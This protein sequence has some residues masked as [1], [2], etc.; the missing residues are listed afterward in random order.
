MKP[1]IKQQ[2]AAIIV[3]LFVTALVAA[4]AI[5]MMQRLAIDTRRTELILNANQTFF[6]AQGAIAW[7]LDQLNNDWKLQ[8]PKQLIDKTPIK[9]TTKQNDTII[10]SVIEDAQA[11]FNLNNLTDKN[12]QPDFKRLLHTIAPKVDEATAQSILLGIID[13][14]TPGLR[15]TTF[16]KY[17]AELNPPYQ[18][19]H[20]P[21]VS[22]SELRLIKDVSAEIYNQLAPFI[23]ALPE[24]TPV[25]VNSAPAPVLM[26]LSKTMTLETAKNLSIYRQQTPFLTLE[27]FS[28]LELVKNNPIPETKITVTSNYFLVKSE[29]TIGQQHTVLNTLVQRVTKEGQSADKKSTVRILWQTK[30]TL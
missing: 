7:S 15:G 5:A 19:P 21:M 22:V 8:K 4:M 18:A 6:D 25:N 29:I 30:G 9:M 1:I 27:Q 28:K 11:N 17:Y 2:G 20:N 16:D 12:F 23:T 10:S 13:W 24:K 3:A 14:I 26:S